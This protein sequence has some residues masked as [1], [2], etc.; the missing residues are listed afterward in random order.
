MTYRP[1]TTLNLQ[2]KKSP[3][4]GCHVEIATNSRM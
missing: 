4:D 3:P 2:Q 1:K